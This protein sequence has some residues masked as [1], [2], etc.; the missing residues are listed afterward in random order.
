MNTLQAIAERY[1]YRG[2]YQDTAVPREA[3]KQIMEG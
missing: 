3:L 2:M 1:S